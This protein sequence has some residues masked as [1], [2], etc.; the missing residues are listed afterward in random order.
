M[1]GSR[2]I[3][4]PLP[5]LPG[6]AQE[7]APGV[8]L[9]PLLDGGGQMWVHGMATFTWDA[10]DE[11]GRRLAAVQVTQLKA[12]TQKQVAAALGTGQ[13]TVWRW[14]AA[15]RKDGLAGLLPARKGPRGPAKLTPELT[16][17]IRG[18]DAQGLG[19][20]A[21]AGQCGVSTFTVRTALGRVPAGP[22]AAA[23][24][25]DGQPPAAGDAAAQDDAA[26][27]AAD[28]PADQGGPA[29][30][31]AD[32]GAAADGT[33]GG[34]EAAEPA[35]GGAELPVLP[36]PAARDGERALARFGLLGEGAAPVFIPGA[37]YPLAGQLLALP[38]LAD[39][40]LLACARQVY[41]R[42]RDGYYS[43]DTVLVHL[44]FQALLREPRA[45]GATRV[46]PPAMG[47]VPGLDRAPE[48]KTIRRKLAELAAAGKAADLQMAIA[49][50]HAEAL[51][52]QLGFLYIDG[53]TRAY[54]GQRDVQKMHV[55]RLK[56]PGPATEETW[57]TD[58]A[59]DP[60]LVV[61]AE[62][63]TSLAAQIKELLPGLR[64]IA[65]PDARPVLC[66]DRGGWSPD[67]F[68]EIIDA[69]FDLLT[70]RKASAGED[71][72][73]LPADAFT[74]ISHA[75]DDGRE[76]RYE[77][78]DGTA[79]ITVTQG[80]H[81]GRVLTLRQVTRLDK[82]RQIRILT[83]RQAGDLPPASVVFGMGSRWREENYF[84]YGRAHFALDALDTYA[85]TPEDP[86]RKVPNPAKKT[87]AFAVKTAKKD[88][89]AAEAARDARLTALRSPAPGQPAVLITNQALA[90][91]DTPVTTARQ[92]LAGAQAAAKA[93]PAK[94]PLA[95][96]NPDMVRLD[97]E[98]KL[99]THAIR[100]AACNAETTLAR[101]LNG[102]Y[103]RADD[104]AY[105]LIREA[106]TTSGDITPAD[107]TLT[108][109]LDPLSAPRRTRALAA[110]CEKLTA[111]AA[112]YPGTTLTLR[113]QVKEPP[114]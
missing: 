90:K 60:L 40:G 21:I 5:W 51:P 110:L 92:R 32:A 22:R 91:L 69:G 42:L 34:G 47:R 6:G 106:L 102:A 26:E 11:A 114:A 66:F 44:V 23:P 105:A 55:A 75:G 73:D 107:G 96:H 70:Y 61:M 100:M 112:T 65:G 85:V 74:A 99:I 111:T 45:E 14:A 12:A 72:P 76:H 38:A 62:P 81:K 103:A 28:A 31:D 33:A 36:E 113:Y 109:R 46:P 41:G 1:T 43:L 67:L 97:T 39:T 86:D 9:L 30:Q 35:S 52:D 15:F 2:L 10:G 16:A 57:V 3:Q 54:F 25:R 78:A 48:V 79:D 98:T 95:Q 82:G 24:A 93:I 80:A 83:T 101:A 20:E 49:R 77:L 56:F 68:A 59:G 94:I 13:V 84:R 58:G 63:S 18:L 87:T 50:W 88:L 89:A 4:A 71:I 37:R 104:E 108:I 8:G 19:V 53:H 64:E 17:K 27:D 29:G 7:I